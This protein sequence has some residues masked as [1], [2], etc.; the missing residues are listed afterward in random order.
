[1][2]KITKRGSDVLAGTDYVTA[3]LPFLDRAPIAAKRRTR[4]QPSRPYVVKALQNLYPDH[5]P[6]RVEV[7]DDDLLA[8]VVKWMRGDILRKIY[9]D[10]VPSHLKDFESHMQVQKQ[11]DMEVREYLRP[12]GVA[13]PV[14]KETVR[15]ASG[16]RV[17]K[18]RRRTPWPSNS[19]Q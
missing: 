7:S 5:R 9:P 2:P 14:S 19:A 11:S 6:S 1:M 13:W 17:D 18:P 10:G 12:Y 15:R 16:R 8:A 3:L 4:K